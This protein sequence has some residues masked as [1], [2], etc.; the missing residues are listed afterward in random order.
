MHEVLMKISKD[1]VTVFTDGSAVE[2]VRDG[3][4]GVVIRW[5]GIQ[6]DELL[7]AQCG[8]SFSSY[9]AEQIAIHTALHHIA[10]SK[11]SLT[12]VWL[13]TDSKSV[14]DPLSM[15][16]AH[17]IDATSGKIWKLPTNGNLDAMGSWSQECCRQ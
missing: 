14:L 2:S 12:E 16:P 4:A 9:K 10:D 17:Q 11:P 8:Q 13:F 1:D 15:G 6:D 7:K 3:G 5:S